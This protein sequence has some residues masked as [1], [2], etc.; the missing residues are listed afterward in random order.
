MQIS[1]LKI[2]GLGL[3]LVGLAARRRSLEEMQDKAPMG[4]MKLEI[5]NTLPVVKT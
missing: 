4:I 3:G 1:K 5:A 2:L